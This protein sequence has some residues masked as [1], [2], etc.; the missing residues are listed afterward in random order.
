MVQAKTPS[1]VALHVESSGSGPAVLLM[2][3]FA[4]SARNFRPQAR[5][6][7]DAYRTILFDARGHARSEAPVA[8]DAY[9]MT[10]FVGDAARVLDES[11]LAEAVVGGLS[12]GS[13][14][15]MWASA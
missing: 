4:G 10:H 6:L 1:D 8:P 13:A 5:A 15:A 7:A 2:H 11:G 3:G 12:L 14:V 9:R